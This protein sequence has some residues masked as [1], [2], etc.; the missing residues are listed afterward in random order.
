MNSVTWRQTEATYR[1]DLRMFHMYPVKG[2][3][4]GKE[5]GR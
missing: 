1:K 5:R 4:K 2:E 3:R